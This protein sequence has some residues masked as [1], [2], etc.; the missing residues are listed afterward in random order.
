MT[1]HRPERCRLV[2]VDVSDDT[3][4][5][6]G[7]ESPAHGRGWCRRH[8]LRWYR[9]GDPNFPPPVDFHER[10]M[11]NVQVT[12][13]CWMWT[14]AANPNGYGQTRSA[15]G[16]KTYAHRISYKLRHGPIREGLEIDH[17]CNVRKCVNPDHL[18]AVTPAENS[19]RKTERDKSAR[20]Q[21]SGKTHCQKGHP[22]DESNTHI[23]RSGARMCRKC[24]A[25][26]VARWR[27]RRAAAAGHVT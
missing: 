11:A 10:F 23:R 1:T 26:G 19:R 6:P 7:C 16:V 17:L 2:G 12:S 9:T 25:A 8:Y 5:I 3:C 14:G 13:G 20:N 21:F 22:F 18:E 27:A 24:H 15:D 4:A